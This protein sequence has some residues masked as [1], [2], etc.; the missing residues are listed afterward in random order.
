M[1]NSEVETPRND[2]SVGVYLKYTPDSG[3][4]AVSTQKRVIY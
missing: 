2:A 3:F 1:Y 4:E